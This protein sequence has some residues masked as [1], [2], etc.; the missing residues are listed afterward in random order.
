[1]EQHEI[2]FKFPTS[3]IQEIA[4]I[5]NN[6]FMFLVQTKMG[7]DK[8]VNGPIPDIHGMTSATQGLTE[9]NTMD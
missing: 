4:F 6:H 8:Q 2:T 9:V 3:P 7:L 1:M 5:V